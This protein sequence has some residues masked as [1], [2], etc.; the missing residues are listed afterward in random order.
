MKKN[1]EEQKA[2]ISREKDSFDQVMVNL[3]KQSMKEGSMDRCVPNDNQIKNEETIN[4]FMQKSCTVVLD[5]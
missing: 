3:I 5:D 1:L 2:K 4:D